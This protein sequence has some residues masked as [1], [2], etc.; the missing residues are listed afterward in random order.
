MVYTRSNARIQRESA[1]EDFKSESE[2]SDE[3]DEGIPSRMTIHPSKRPGVVTLRPQTYVRPAK[4]TGD[5]V[6]LRSSSSKR[7][8]LSDQVSPSLDRGF[9]LIPASSLQTAPQALDREQP[10]NENSSSDTEN[11]VSDEVIS[12]IKSILKLRNTINQQPPREELPSKPLVQGELVRAADHRDSR[13]EGEVEAEEGSDE[14]A[15][16]DNPHIEGE[17]LVGSVQGSAVARNDEQGAANDD[18]SALPDQRASL[19]DETRLSS[20]P[21]EYPDLQQDPYEV[22]MSPPATIQLEMPRSASTKTRRSQRISSRNCDVGQVSSFR[23]PQASTSAPNDISLQ[24]QGVHIPG[25]VQGQVVANPVQMTTDV[26][27]ADSEEEFEDIQ[28]FALAKKDKRGSVEETAE[29][30]SEQEHSD[31]HEQSE[32][33]DGRWR[34]RGDADDF[35][36]RNSPFIDGVELEVGSQTDIDLSVEESFSRDVELFRTR[37]VPDE[38]LFEIFEG[39]PEDDLTTIHLHPDF[40]ERALRLMGSK[41]WTGL[42]TSWQSRLSD[43][44]TA[45]TTPGRAIMLLLRKLRRLYNA[46]PNA[47]YLRDQNIF[48]AKHSDVITYY[49]SKIQLVVDHIRTARLGKPSRN[50]SATNRSEEKR[51]EVAEEIV[52]L[53]IPTVLQVLAV[54]WTLGDDGEGSTQ[55]TASTAEF[56]MRGIGWVNRLYYPALRQLSKEKEPRKTH[57]KKEWSGKRRKREEFGPLVDALVDQLQQAPDMLLEKEHAESVREQNLRRQK[58]KQ[59]QWERDKQEREQ[60]IREQNQRAYK[61]I[62]AETMTPTLPSLSPSARI[63]T[64]M[65]PSSPLVW[66]WSHEEKEFLFEHLRQSY[67]KLPDLSGYVRQELNRDLDDIKRMAGDILRVMLKEACEEAGVDMSA[68]DR[69]VEIG[70]IFRYS[71]YSFDH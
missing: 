10:S 1:A 3:D 5:E 30:D 58:R 39:P 37:H 22:P 34:E 52:S 8:R 49:F 48:L 27:V 14:S 51:N 12:S 69:E 63:T 41:G 44:A 28:R 20:A 25:D 45:E 55:F 17:G 18:L 19:D 36:D 59:M 66:Q 2:N 31:N 6:A 21:R 26:E 23:S 42:H 71:G 56:L 35:D 16:T 24:I 67:P 61:S 43:M 9:S 38:E 46:V 54:A 60:R 57:A 13:H 15:E 33:S 7:Q 11:E 29:G 62:F 4:R 47:P 40:L 32:A 64:T 53:I 65:P 68:A 50:A 70:G